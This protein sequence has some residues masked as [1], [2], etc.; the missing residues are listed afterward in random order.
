ML[1]RERKETIFRCRLSSLDDVVRIL[2]L[3]FLRFYDIL[4]EISEFACSEAQNA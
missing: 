3:I 1:L 4:N 2:Q